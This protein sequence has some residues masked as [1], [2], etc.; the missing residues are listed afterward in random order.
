M[1]CIAFVATCLLTGVL[2]LSNFGASDPASC[3]DNG[4]GPWEMCGGV[5]VNTNIDDHNCQYCDNDCTAGGRICSAGHCVIPG[6]PRGPR[7]VREE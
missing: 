2:L 7:K 4:G 6:E 3:P 5:C 1:K